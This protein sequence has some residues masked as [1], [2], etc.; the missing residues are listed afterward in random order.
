MAEGPRDADCPLKSCQLH[1]IRAKKSHLK[2]LAAG[3]CRESIGHI[4]F[5]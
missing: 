4:A 2:T 1:H 3:V 5:Y